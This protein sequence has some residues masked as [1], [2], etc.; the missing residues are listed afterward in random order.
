MCPVGHNHQGEHPQIQT[1]QLTIADVDDE[2]DS[3]LA[4]A[5]SVLP[6]PVQ[7]RISN[8]PAPI[9]LPKPP[10]EHGA[11]ALGNPLAGPGAD[12]LDAPLPPHAGPPLSEQN[13]ADHVGNTGYSGA[14]ETL[15]TYL[16]DLERPA[17]VHRAPASVASTPA[18]AGLPSGS[19]RV[20]TSATLSSASGLPSFRTSASSGAHPTPSHLHR[21]TS[22]A[23]HLHTPSTVTHAAAV[24]PAGAAT[25]SSNSTSS[26]SH[27][28]LST[29]QAPRAA[30]AA[31]Q[32][33][34]AFGATSS[35]APRV[36]VA[37]SY[38][39]QALPMPRFASM[40]QP[41]A[42]P[43]VAAVFS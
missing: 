26:G 31:E 7:R 37:G 4:Q 28:P 3:G 15:R 35:A 17:L 22:V 2:D 18:S 13:L 10:T 25:K 33:A 41:R 29:Y 40:L 27:M 23:S 9:Q 24:R 12:A 42:A 5:T 6:A 39:A 11:P 30:T 21:R 20:P 34:W 43:A 36:A 38:V 1:Q 19:F 8:R 14:N 32:L 16:R